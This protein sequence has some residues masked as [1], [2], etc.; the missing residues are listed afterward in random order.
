MSTSKSYITM[1]RNALKYM[2]KHIE[3]F[4]QIKEKKHP[5]YK[6]AREFFKAK[7]ICFQNFYKFYARFIESGR[8]EEELLPRRRGRAKYKEM[9]GGDKIVEKVLEYREKRYNRY[10][11]AEAIR[12]EGGEKEVRSASTVYRILRKLGR[13]RLS[14]IKKEE[15]EKRK[16]ERKEMGSLVHVDCHYLGK[17]IVNEE[18]ERRYYVMGVIDTKTRLGWVEVIERVKGIETGFAMMDIIMIMKAR[19]GVEIEEVLTDNGSEFCGGEKKREHGFERVLMYFGIKHRRTKAYRPQTNGKIERY[20][21]TFNEEVI[22]GVEYETLEELREEI[23]GYNIYYNEYRPHQGI[24]GKKPI[25]MIT[26]EDKNVIK[27]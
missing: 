1:E 24:N 7:G 4:E 23:L 2:L 14:Q 6:N 19:Y 17:G 5:I 12:N 13:S 15:E 25:E 9:P 3:E 11:I 26:E 18:K 10:M 21:R 27:S 22:E 8:K 16:I 20:W